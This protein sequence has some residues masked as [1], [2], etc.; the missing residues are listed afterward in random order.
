MYINVI[1]H[2]LSGT[3][4]R[5][6]WGQ[7]GHTPQTKDFYTQVKQILQELSNIPFVVNRQTSFATLTNIIPLTGLSWWMKCGEFLGMDARNPCCILND[8]LFYIETPHS[9]P[10]AVAI[11][12][13]FPFYTVTNGVSV[14][15]GIKHSGLTTN[16]PCFISRMKDV[17]WSNVSN[18]L[19]S[20]PNAS[21]ESMLRDMLMSRDHRVYHLGVDLFR[22]KTLMREDHLLAI[23][24]EIG[25]WLVSGMTLHLIEHPACVSDPMYVN[26]TWLFLQ[27]LNVEYTQA[28]D[29]YVYKDLFVASDVSLTKVQMIS[30][31]IEQNCVTHISVNDV[32]RTVNLAITASG[33]SPPHAV[34]IYASEHPGGTIPGTRHFVPNAPGPGTCFILDTREKKPDRSR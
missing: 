34:T 9:A 32:F 24:K 11:I 23:L 33:H 19:K 13:V 20:T 30:V 3:L 12:T 29:M 15:F 2:E 8:G 10:R 18:V 25:N 4:D 1:L 27:Q 14:L 6:L 16:V 22:L 7:R 26:P 31:C 28:K 17:I 5:I 21:F